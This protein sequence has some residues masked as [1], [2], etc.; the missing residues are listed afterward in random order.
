MLNASNQP[1]RNTKTDLN[2]HYTFAN[3]AYGDYKITVEVA[4]KTSDVISVNLS[5]EN[6]NSG[7]NNFQTG[8]NSYTAVTA[9]NE[10]FLE[11]S[12]LYPNPTTGKLFVEFNTSKSMNIELQV[13]DNLGNLVKENYLQSVNSINK[14]VLDLSD[15]PKGIYSLRMIDTNGQLATRM[16]IKL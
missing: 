2:G 9:I 3:L 7:S 15:L 16:I 5:K 11:T 12:S 1:V 4:G 14:I 13:F 8:T 6:P 10:N